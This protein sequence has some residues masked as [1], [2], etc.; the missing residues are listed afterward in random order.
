[1]MAEKKKTGIL[2]D[3]DGTLWDS[4]AAVVDSWNVVL[5][6]YED[7]TRKATIEWMQRLMGKTM[8]DIENMFLDY[9]PPERRHVLMKE[10]L[11]YENEYI[12]VHG[13]ILFEGVKE[14]L[15]L[16]KKDYH[17]SVVSNCQEGYVPAF[18]K[19][20]GME[21][22]FDDYE[23]YGRTGKVKADNISLV[24]KRNNLEQAV[25]VGDT[26]GD[27]NS[28]KE[29]GLPFIHAAYGYGEVPERTVKITDIRELPQAVKKIFR[30]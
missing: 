11:D 16:L 6:K 5:D 18:F 19:A 29:A 17:L 4:S 20:H 3:L 22:L 28:T 24:V 23:E 25:Y 26:L 30:T 2:F 9:L 21:Q 7:A 8:I 15:E 14:T 27:Y 10:C 13:G 12:A 1:M